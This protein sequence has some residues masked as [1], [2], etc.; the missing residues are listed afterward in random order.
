V[1]IAAAPSQLAVVLRASDTCSGTLVGRAALGS[2]FVELD[3]DAVGRLRDE[4]APGTVATLLDAPDAVRAEID[5]WGPADRPSIELMRRVKARFDPS[6]TCNP[7][8][9]VDGI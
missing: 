8:L 4:L 3:P 2:S 7:G 1:R 5:P 6:G 9:F